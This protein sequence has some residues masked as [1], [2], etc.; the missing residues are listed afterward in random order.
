MTSPLPKKLLH[1]KRHRPA[2]AQPAAARLWGLSEVGMV[3]ISNLCVLPAPYARNVLPHRLL[4]ACGATADVGW[5]HHIL[6]AEETH[7]MELFWEDIETSCLG[8][9]GTAAY[10]GADRLI[11]WNP[12]PAFHGL[13]LRT[14]RLGEEGLQERVDWGGLRGAVARQD[15]TRA[16]LLAGCGPADAWTPAEA[17]VLSA[18]LREPSVMRTALQV[19]W[20]SVN[21][22]QRWAPAPLVE[23]I[24][25][26][27]MRRIDR[28]MTA[29]YA[30]P[31]VSLSSKEAG[32][33]PAR[34]DRGIH[35]PR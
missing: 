3:P 11:A 24:R 26:W 4:P 31:V 32:P 30:A 29:I 18:A 9:A 6:T 14:A 35:P 21:S 15:W 2:Q 20:L 13:D 16:W 17:Y 22:C 25:Q 10:L 28:F 5:P 33:D 1:S 12:A 7:P 19:A 8:W 34:E 23:S 27:E